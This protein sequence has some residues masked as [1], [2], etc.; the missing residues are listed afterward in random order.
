MN[1]AYSTHDEEKKMT[2]SE[3]IQLA[4]MLLLVLIG[5]GVLILFAGFDYLRRRA[6]QQMW[7]ELA[8]RT[9]LTFE[10]GGVLSPMRITGTYRGHL[11]TLDT[12]TQRN[13]YTRII[14]SVNNPSALTLAIYDG[15]VLSKI[16]K[17]LGKQGIQVG[18]DELDQR[19]TF[20]GQPET[21][22]VGLLTSISLRQKLLEAGSLH[23]DVKDRELHFEQR[24]EESNA[25][26][27]QFLF[28]LLGDLAEAI[29]R[30]GGTQTS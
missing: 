24:G 9:S 23:V 28:D 13:T 16:G 29:D 15:N 14:L 27:L 8:A 21:V 1:R 20:K 10:P 5:I 18:D 6:R 25:D 17:A 22:I 12:F 26:R 2:G 19:F 4:A 3:T 11:L 7:S 30:A